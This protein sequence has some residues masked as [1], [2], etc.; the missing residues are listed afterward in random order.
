MP[1]YLAVIKP[2]S[3]RIWLRADES[4]PGRIG[5]RDVRPARV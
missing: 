5:S 4:T 1:N 2:A 3:I